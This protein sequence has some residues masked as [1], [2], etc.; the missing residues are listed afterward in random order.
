M[1]GG[2]GRRGWVSCSAFLSSSG[3]CEH[4]GSIHISAFQI[5]GGTAAILPAIRNSVISLDFLLNDNV[6]ISVQFTCITVVWGRISMF[7]HRIVE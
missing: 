3:C 1:I 6:I 5:E 7:L 4:L 2:E